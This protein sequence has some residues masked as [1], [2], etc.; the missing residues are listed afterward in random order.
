M[1][2]DSAMFRTSFPPRHLSTRRALLA[3]SPTHALSTHPSPLTQPHSFQLDL[4]TS[5][6]GAYVR[7]GIVTQYKEPKQLSFKTLKAALSEPGEFLLTDFSKMERPALLHLAFQALDMFEVCV[8]SR[9]CI[10]GWG[11][12]LM[13]RY[14]WAPVRRTGRVLIYMIIFTRRELA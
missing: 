4:D 1:D 3:H 11:H 6:Y 10:S 9:Q 13:M 14:G 2:Q 12:D 7:G 5:T 8:C